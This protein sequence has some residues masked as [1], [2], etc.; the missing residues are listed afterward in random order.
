[1]QTGRILPAFRMFF[2]ATNKA[3]G[4]DRDRNSG[5]QQSPERDATEE[6]ARRAA[7]LLSASD[8]FKQ[9]GILVSVDVKDGRSVLLVRDAAGTPLRVIQSHEIVRILLSFGSPQ[10]ARQGRILDRRI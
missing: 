5:G 10:A 2:S 8:E 1:M 7:E 3:G 9:N 4:S 6:E